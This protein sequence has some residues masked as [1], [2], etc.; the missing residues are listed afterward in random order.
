[1]FDA[2]DRRFM[3]MALALAEKGE[4]LA[5]PNPSVGCI[6]VRDGRVVGR[7]MHEYSL[8]DHA[9]VRA[10]REASGLSTDATAYVTLEPCCHHGRTAPCVDGLIQAGIRRVVVARI[11]PNPQVSGKG[12]QRLKSSGIRVDAGLM[13]EEAGRLIENFACRITTGLPLVVGKVGMTLDGK[14]GTGRPDGRWI[15]SP[16]SREF[17]QRLRLGADGLLV[18]VHTVLVDD[19]ELTYRGQAAKARPLVRIVLDSQ[20]RTPVSA[21]LFQTVPLSPVLIFCS[22]R[23]SK[24]NQR[25][26][27]RRG[28]E[29]VRISHSQNGLDLQAVLQELGQRNVLELLVEGGS[30]VHWSFLSANLVDKFYFIVA[31]L[32]LGGTDAIL[33]VGGRGFRTI[34]DAAKFKVSRCFSIGPDV[35]LETYPSCSRSIISPWLSPEISPSAPRYFE[36]ALKRK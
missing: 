29:I 24:R 3:K 27:E 17:G 1:M 5:S 23:A 4:G 16:E 33:S 31:P 13:S 36:P 14:I 12:I 32:V 30:S 2:A 8:K 9:E 25:E 7:G 15:T 20:L 10:L 22:H 18:G 6:I 28:A 11:D 21:N 35:I 19:P 26:L 34:K